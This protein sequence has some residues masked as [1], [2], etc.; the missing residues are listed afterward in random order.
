MKR[1]NA[2]EVSAARAEKERHL[3]EIFLTRKQL[4]DRHQTTI[5]TVKRRQAR[6][7]YVAYKLGRSIRYKLSEV[8][9]AENVG[10]V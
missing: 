9:A 10:R 1:A 6:G 8:V 2:I 4:A 5:E 3:E 7:F